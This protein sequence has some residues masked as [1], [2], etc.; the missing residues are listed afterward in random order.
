MGRL[1]TLWQEAPWTLQ[2]YVGLGVLVSFV[3]IALSPTPAR[4][5][6]FAAGLVLCFFLL[7][8]IRWL[9]LLDIAVTAVYFVGF[10]LVRGTNAVFMLA[11][12]ALLLAAQTRQHFARSSTVRHG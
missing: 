7:R 4:W 3:G 6:T 10:L 11:A 5:V 8:R 2:V 9:W 1:R 12:L